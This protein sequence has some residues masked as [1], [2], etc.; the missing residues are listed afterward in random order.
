MSSGWR[1]CE[2]KTRF[3][4]EEY[5]TKI[6][7]K[8]GNQRAYHCNFCNGFHLSSQP[9]RPAD[10]PKKPL[11]LRKQVQNAEKAVAELKRKKI[12]GRFLEEAE[13][14]LAELERR[15]RGCA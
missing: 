2:S 15:L 14:H 10:P 5:A 8:Y 1:Q 9:P 13:R 12:S 7:S 3:S 6:G 11:N 4:T